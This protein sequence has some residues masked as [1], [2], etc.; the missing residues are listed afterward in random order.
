MFASGNK[1]IMDT[2][3]P[4]LTDWHYETLPRQAK[5]AFDFL[6]GEEWL[7]KSKWYLAGGTALAL[8]VGHRKSLD[9]DFF[10]E[11]PKF[12]PEIYFK[13]GWREVKDFFQKEI[14]AIAKEIIIQSK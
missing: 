5:K 8:Q 6:S 14:S 3:C 10:S 11:L 1:S 12:D 9:L 4:K 2:P 7:K 13:A